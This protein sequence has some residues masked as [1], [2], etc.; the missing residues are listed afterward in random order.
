MMANELEVRNWRMTEAS[1]SGLHLWFDPL[2]ETVKL[3]ELDPGEFP[4][5]HEVLEGDDHE[6]VYDPEV[7][8]NEL[9][10]LPF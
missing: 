5:V 1:P 10:E 3:F 8:K 2:R 9:G 7:D 4:G 6:D